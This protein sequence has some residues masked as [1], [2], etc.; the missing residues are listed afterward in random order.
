MENKENHIGKYH[1]NLSTYNLWSLIYMI[2]KTIERYSFGSIYV[3]S[4]SKAWN[5]VQFSE[6]KDR[7]RSKSRWILA[8]KLGLTSEQGHDRRMRRNEEYPIQYSPVSFGSKILSKI[9]GLHFK[10]TWNQPKREKALTY[11]L[12]S[13]SF[14]VWQAIFVHN[15]TSSDAFRSLARVEN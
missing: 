12:I 11:L 7:K 9:E 13:F 8:V 14:M 4:G 15:P 3:C 6:T 10:L 5:Q 2:K 1:Y